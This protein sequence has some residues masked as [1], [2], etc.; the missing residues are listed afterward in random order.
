MKLKK[1]FSFCQPQ[2]NSLIIPPYLYFEEVGRDTEFTT[3]NGFI[4]ISFKLELILTLCFKA[5][6]HF[7]VTPDGKYEKMVNEA[8]VS[9]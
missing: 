7:Q 9:P 2:N 5:Q 3:P 1:C 8:L 4:L 6:I